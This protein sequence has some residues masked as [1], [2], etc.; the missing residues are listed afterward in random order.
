MEKYN[1]EG[2][3][4]FNKLPT[5]PPLL[6][7]AFLKQMELGA[8]VVDTRQPPSFGGAH[9][10][11]TYSIWLE[12][13]PSYAGWTLSYDKPIL[14]ILEDKNYLKKA[15]RYL[16]RMG[17]DNLIGY[18]VGG[19]EAWYTLSLPLQNFGLISVQELKNW[20]NNNED[21]FILD[22]REDE[23]WNQGHIPGSVN[24]FSGYLENHIG[25]VPKNRRI[26]V[27]CNIGNRASLAASILT[28]NGFH[29]VH[30]VL[31]GMIAWK[32]ANYEITKS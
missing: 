4:Q 11:N 14:L 6:P 16:Y 12:R 17:Y 5:P 9:L 19:V 3:P 30:N 27:I 10:K 24:I 22:V 28:R 23:K 29:D 15:V 2:P 31:G 1:L 7:Q 25:A 26:I 20:M 13:I 32:N 8:V 21:L 18:L